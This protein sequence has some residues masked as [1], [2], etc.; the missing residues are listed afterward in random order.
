MLRY[1]VYLKLLSRKYMK[2]DNISQVIQDL[3]KE[4]EGM[5]KV[6]ASFFLLAI[7]ILFGTG[8][9]FYKSHLPQETLP[10]GTYSVQVAF[11]LFSRIALIIIAFYLVRLLMSVVSYNLALSN[12]L[13]AKALSLSLFKIDG[14][15]SLNELYEHLGINHHIFEASKGFS[16]KDEMNVFL[17][18]LKVHSKK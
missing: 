11:S 4:S 1:N 10:I 12:D 14:T 9:L 5:Q 18:A 16:G 8:F 7:M 2:E 3:K 13:K 17:N 6:A 15:L